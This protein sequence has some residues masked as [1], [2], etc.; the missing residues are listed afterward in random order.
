MASV[1]PRVVARVATG[2]VFLSAC[3][4]VPRTEV[5]APSPKD[6]V[7]SPALLPAT[8]R[9]LKR[10][11][12][13]ARFSNETT[14]GKSPLLGE[15][16]LGRQASDILSTRLTDT[17]KF[18]LL[19]S[20]VGAEGPA[21]LAADYK[22]LGSV[23]EFGRAISGE[24][25]VFSK[26]KTQTARAAVNLRVVDVRTGVVIFSAAGRGEAES[27]S[28]K[29]FGVGTSQGFDS[30]LSERAI[31]AAI[32]E[33]VGNVVECLL[34]APWRSFVLAID[35]DTCTIGGG[36][37]QGIATGD[38]FVVLRR[39]KAVE[40]PQTGALIDL[41]GELVAEIEV[42]RSIGD[43]YLEEVSMCRVLTGSLSGA[44]SAELIVQEKRR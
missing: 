17:R 29:V 39:G 41:P 28:G 42:T 18:I 7:L 9:F 35:G 3:A 26:T 4:T 31:S 11:V 24:T 21:A 2:L 25:G 14:Y 22:V 34:D 16:V 1:R 15:D 5:V 27:T 10:K 13:I 37:N 8:G 33:V 12:A 20:E 30:T 19:E 44:P 38:R 6:P 32:S 36:V 23:S 43:N 40:N